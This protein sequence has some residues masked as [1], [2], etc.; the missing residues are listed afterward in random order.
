MNIDNEIILQRKISSI[1]YVY[2]MII[3]VI[4]LS[5]IILIMMSSYRTYYFVKGIVIEEDQNYYV[6]AYI[7]LEDIKY[8]IKD[9]YVIIDNKKYNYK[10]SSIEEEY[11]TDNLNTYQII[12]FEIAL[13][14]K[15][16]KNN[17]TIDL[18]FLKEDKKAIEYILKK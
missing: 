18:K 1:V 17:L 8:L 11:F 12:K 16:Q 4:T 14:E 6:K 9:T 10:L 5:L 13:E 3:I 15:Y 7:P 2:I